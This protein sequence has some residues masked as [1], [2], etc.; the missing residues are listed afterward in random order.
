MISNISLTNFRRF[1]S[2]T[3][4]TNNNLVILVG[5]NA[6]GKTSVLEAIYLTSTFK[7][8][9]SSSTFYLIKENAPFSKI[10]ISTDNKKYQVILSNNS[11]KGLIDN[12]DIKRARDFV[13][14]LHTVFF[15]PQDLNLVTGSPSI[16]RNFLDLE[17]SML[18]KKYLDCLS[19]AKYYLHERNEAL[20]TNTNSKMIDVLTSSL[21]SYETLIVKSRIKFINL[22]NEKLRDVHFAISNGERLEIKYKM[23]FPLE[24][25][26]DYYK[27]SFQKDKVLKT[28]CQGFHRDDFSILLN[29][30]IASIYSSEGQIRNI[31]I[32]MKIALV[33]VYE[34]Y[35]NESPILLLDDVFSELDKDRQANL[36]KF[37]L[38][39]PQTFITTTSLDE[40]TNELLNK[41]LIIKLDKEK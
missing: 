31:A 32:S 15:S 41:A 12:I 25:T 6:L 16:R 21:I 19:K 29:D 38:N 24:N 26:M 28:T 3:L 10:N 9:R 30:K 34:Q 11:K 18:N 40:I 17:L 37:L 39:R 7:S 23:S 36:I 27:E 2:L 13:G 14:N 4:E 22:L 35:L 33:M 5:S 1:D 20:K 8:Y